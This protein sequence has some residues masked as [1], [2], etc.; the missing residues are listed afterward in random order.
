MQAVARVE[1]LAAD[2]VAK[3]A[4]SVHHHF[5]LRDLFCAAKFDAAGFEFGPGA[6][7]EVNRRALTVKPLEKIG[8]SVWEAQ[9]DKNC[10]WYK[11][12][13]LQLR[14]QHVPVFVVD[15]EV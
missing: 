11:Y 4:V 1:Q 8:V 14:C 5:Q 15:F 7:G 3:Q 13:F 2:P 9:P 6:L 12:T 10:W